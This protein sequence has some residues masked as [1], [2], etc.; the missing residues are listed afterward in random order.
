MDLR[1]F[2]PKSAM[3]WYRLL[4]ARQEFGFHR[5][6]IGFTAGVPSRRLA[7]LFAA[8]FPFAI[9]RCLETLRPLK[10]LPWCRPLCISLTAFAT[11]FLEISNCA[12]D[13]IDSRSAR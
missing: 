3:I 1:A 5:G 8:G 6:H 2:V 11:V 13:L 9:D 7:V 10:E 12:I 4:L